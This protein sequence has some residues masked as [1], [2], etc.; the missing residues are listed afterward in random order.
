MVY[1][2]NTGIQVVLLRPL[3]LRLPSGEEHQGTARRLVHVRKLLTGT[4]RPHWLPGTWQGVQPAC[5]FVHAGRHAI[6]VS[7]VQGTVGERTISTQP[8]ADCSA[9]D[10]ARENELEHAYAGNNDHCSCHNDEHGWRS[11]SEPS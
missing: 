6:D 11:P 5:T 9:G 2:W 4:H 3:S 8:Q 7:S 1:V 10:Q